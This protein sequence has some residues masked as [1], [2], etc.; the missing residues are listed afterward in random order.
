MPAP[1]KKASEAV[2]GAELPSPVLAELERRV[3]QVKQ[4]LKQRHR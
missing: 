3:N 4:P 2:D 1:K